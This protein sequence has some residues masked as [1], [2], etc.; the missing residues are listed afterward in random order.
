MAHFL[1]TGIS[2]TKKNSGGRGSDV[3]L[4]GGGANVVAKCSLHFRGV[5]GSNPGKV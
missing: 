2:E 3:V 5:A 1:Q 4:G